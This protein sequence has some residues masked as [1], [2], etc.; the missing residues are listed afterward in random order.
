M[1][2]V[3]RAYYTHEKVVETLFEAESLGVNTVIARA[4]DNAIGYLKRFWQSGGKLQWFSQTC[5]ELGDPAVSIERAADAGAAACYI[6]GGVMDNL[7][8]QNGLDII[9]DCIRLMRQRGMLAGIAAHN[10]AVFRWAE[11][12]LDADFYMCAYYDPIPRDQNAAHVHGAHEVYL[13][14]DRQAMT[15]TIQT[16]SKPAIHYKILAAGRNDPAEAFSYAAR[17]MRPQ[18]AVCVGIYSQSQPNMLQEDVR[19][20]LELQEQG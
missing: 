13:E 1:D 6:H 15:A 20:F 10:P 5:P 16:L 11:A 4:D 3:M 9:P 12:N 7:L 14:S 2:G 8:A 17:A 18:D 19:L